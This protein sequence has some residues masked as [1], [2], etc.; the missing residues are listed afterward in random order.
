MED[1]LTLF[2]MSDSSTEFSGFSANSYLTPSSP[3]MTTVRTPE[4]FKT[5]KITENLYSH[6]IRLDNK[7]I[8]K[9]SQAI[10]DC[11]E[12][13]IVRKKEENGEIHRF[14]FQGKDVHVTLYLNGT[15]HV[16]GPTHKQW[17]QSEFPHLLESCKMEEIESPKTESGFW[18]KIASAIKSPFRKMSPSSSPQR[19]TSSTSEQD[20]LTSTPLK[21]SSPDSS[22]LFLNEKEYRISSLLLHGAIHSLKSTVD[23]LSIPTRTWLSDTEN[24]F[25]HELSTSADDLDILTD[26]VRELTNR[27]DKL[28]MPPAYEKPKHTAASQTDQ[29]TKDSM[30]YSASIPKVLCENALAK[31]AGHSQIDSKFENPKSSHEKTKNVEKIPPPSQGIP[32]AM[33]GQEDKINSNLVGNTSCIT[34]LMGDS[35]TK[36]FKETNCVKKLRAPTMEKAITTLEKIHRQQVNL[37]DN[38]TFIVGTNDLEKPILM[39]TEMAD[40]M[41]S[42]AKLCCSS[43]KNVNICEIPPRYD[44]LHEYTHEANTILAN[45]AAKHGVQFTTSPPQLFSGE[46]MYFYNRDGLHL[47]PAG[48]QLLADQLGMEILSH[49]GRKPSREEQRNRGLS[50]QSRKAKHPFHQS[51]NNNTRREFRGCF[52]C[53]ELNHTSLRCLYSEALICRRCGIHGHK[54]KFCIR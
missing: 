9:L 6:T 3:N 50:F 1:S 25:N 16:Q 10:N 38:I 42:L 19:S 40:Q 18:K 22:D 49:S 43:V 15:I 17:V 52:H 48:S 30:N 4:T 23:N 11:H 13:D 27:L 45:L 2:D 32:G 47:N 7:F 39:F 12:N 51:Q 34:L 46:H 26:M 29:G 37:Y 35:L 36:P 14:I 28:D 8:P 54:Q 41:I 20:L 31:E 53:G 44:Y 24:L 33:T 21:L 5:V